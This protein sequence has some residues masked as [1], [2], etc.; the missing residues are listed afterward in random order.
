MRSLA[1]PTKEAVPALPARPSNTP[2]GIENDLSPPPE[3]ARAN[4]LDRRAGADPCAKLGA[5][6]RR[7]PRRVPERHDPRLDR[8]PLDRCRLRVHLLDRVEL[9]PKRCRGDTRRLRR[10]ARHAT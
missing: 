10:V 5:L 3:M 4:L 8:H 7:H 2:C 9:D 6:G 1:T